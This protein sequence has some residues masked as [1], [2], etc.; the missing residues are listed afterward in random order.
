MQ[1]GDNLME[2]FAHHRDDVPM[3]ANLK[4]CVTQEPLSIWRSTRARR[5]CAWS[6]RK[7]ATPTL[8]SRREDGDGR[9]PGGDWRGRDDGKREG[10]RDEELPEVPWGNLK[11]MG[12]NLP[13]PRLP[14]QSWR[15]RNPQNFN[16]TGK[17][18][19]F[20]R[21]AEIGRIE[22]PSVGVENSFRWLVRIKGE[23]TGTRSHLLY[24]PK[25]EP[26]AKERKSQ[27]LIWRQTMA[28]RAHQTDTLKQAPARNR[29]PKTTN[30]EERQ[31]KCQS[32]LSSS[33]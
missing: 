29:Q 14:E 5:S 16:E 6:G 25:K 18:D 32:S 28:E 22:N 19:V 24:P 10:K 11:Q 3:G 30:C 7:A 33:S 9:R 2:G 1:E 15:K 12:T 8:K 21:I 23:Q 4:I 17:T 27:Q 26:V 20:W 31:Q 13:P